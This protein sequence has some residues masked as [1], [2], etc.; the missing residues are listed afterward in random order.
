MNKKPGFMNKKTTYSRFPPAYNNH[1][2]SSA[3]LEE[4]TENYHKEIQFL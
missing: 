3:R 1:W 4:K 2:Q